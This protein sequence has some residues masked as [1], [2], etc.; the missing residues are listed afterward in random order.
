M[1]S[2]ACLTRCWCRNTRTLT[3]GKTWS[4]LELELPGNGRILA[5][6]SR[7]SGTGRSG[8]KGLS[9]DAGKSKDS[10]VGNCNEGRLTTKRSVDQDSG[11]KKSTLNASRSSSS[12][13]P[14]VS[15]LLLFARRNFPVAFFLPQL[16]YRR[17][18]NH[19]RVHDTSSISPPYSP[20]PHDSDTPPNSTLRLRACVLPTS[21]LSSRLSKTCCCW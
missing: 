5:G 16:P 3:I 11:L 13:S 15:V 10:D 7:G 1:T 21:T 9:V 4:G 17:P 12:S 6:S 18:H 8:V 2:Y 19:G 20:S 14:W